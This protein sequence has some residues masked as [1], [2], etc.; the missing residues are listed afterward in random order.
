[1]PDSQLLLAALGGWGLGVLVGLVGAARHAFLWWGRGA[2]R[3]TFADTPDGNDEWRAPHLPTGAMA[4]PGVDVTTPLAG[5]TR[6]IC[7]RCGQAWGTCADT[8]NV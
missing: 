3:A 8:R 1:M 7:F 5:G 6:G 2:G 4:T